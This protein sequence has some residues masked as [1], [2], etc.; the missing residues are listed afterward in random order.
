M[1]EI[2]NK[3]KI[4][5]WLLPTE[6]NAIMHRVIM[7]G[8]NSLGGFLNTRN[9]NTKQG[10]SIKQDDQGDSVNRKTYASTSWIKL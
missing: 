2:F 3:F 5:N 10:R 6:C 7:G 9:C 1:V 8:P 4:S